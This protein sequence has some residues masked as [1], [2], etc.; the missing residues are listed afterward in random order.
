LTSQH[1]SCEEVV[2]VVVVRL[3][4]KRV[5]LDSNKTDKLVALGKKKKRRN[6]IKITMLKM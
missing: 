4:F 2:A 3:Y 1:A 6:K 5:A